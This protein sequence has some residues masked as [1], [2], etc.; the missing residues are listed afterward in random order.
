MK[1]NYLW[2][3]K[4]AVALL[5]FLAVHFAAFAQTTTV[6]GTVSDESGES[7]PGV[8]IAVVGTTQG[9]VTD[10]DGSFSIEVSSEASLRFSF[11]GHVDQVIPVKGQKVINVVL[12][13]DVASL[14]EVVV[15]GYG[16][17]KKSDISG[18]VVSVS[19]EDMMRKSPTNIMQ[20]LQG[21]AA[22][23]I[24]TA[25][26]G[27]PDA[28]AAVRIRGIGTINGSAD[29]LYVVDGVQVG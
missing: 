16:S 4:G 6:N 9:T 11:L 25:Q 7:L 3:S 10:F 27:A 2:S 23:V 18:S 14:D 15:V 19:K 20:G 26:D 29:P 1:K 28:N 24:V 21:V 5:F 8:S 12:K 13:L 17:M 22:G